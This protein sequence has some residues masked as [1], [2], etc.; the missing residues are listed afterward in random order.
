MKLGISQQRFGSR[1]SVNIELIKP[2]LALYIGGMGARNKNFY[3]DY[4]CRLGFADAAHKIQDLYLA[5]NKQEAIAAVPDELI[6]A[7]H[8]VGP[9]DKI[10][11]RLVD[12]KASNQRGEVDLMIVGAMQ[13]E[14]LDLPA[15]E[16]L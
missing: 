16:M 9:A 11:E 8:L 5:G 12:W 15:E 1:A 4:A 14:A 6:N 7:G 10:R 3:T 2:N 13:T